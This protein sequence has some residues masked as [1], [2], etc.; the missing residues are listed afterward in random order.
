MENLSKK[1]D[2]LLALMRRPSAPRKPSNFAL[3]WAW[4]FYNLV[5][6]FLDII[7]AFTVFEIT[8]ILYAT[9]TFFAGFGP[10]IMHEFLY[11]R[12]YASKTQRVIAITG[13]ITSVAAIIIIGLLAAGVNVFAETFG[14]EY[15]MWIEL[16]ILALIVLN[17]AWHGILAAV[18]FYVDEGIRTKHNQQEAIAYHETQLQNVNLALNLAEKVSQAAEREDEFIRRFGDRALLD[19]A[20]GQVTGDPT[21]VAQKRNAPAQAYDPALHPPTQ[22]SLPEV[23]SVPQETKVAD[24]AEPMV[25]PA[26]VGFSGNGHKPADPT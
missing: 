1:K 17:S 23:I 24:S 13:A 21:A 5:A 3:W 7:T 16:A 14:K 18:Y 22:P 26:A 8:N 12:A 2:Q 19:E 10:L 25:E 9:L 4:L 20:M 11:L 6:L 15:A